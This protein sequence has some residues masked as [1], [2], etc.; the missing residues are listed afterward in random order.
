M[1]ENNK[2]SYYFTGSQ[3][4]ASIERDI[5]GPAVKDYEVTDQTEFSTLV[6][7]KCNTSIPLNIKSEVRVDTSERKGSNGEITVDS[8]DGKVQFIAGIQWRRC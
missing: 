5:W 3:G 8:V 6:W 7:S 4:T 1:F 2:T